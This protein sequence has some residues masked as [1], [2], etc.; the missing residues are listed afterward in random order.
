[1]TGFEDL[2]GQTFGRLTAVSRVEN[3]PHGA[4]RWSCSCACG[5]VFVVN[6]RAMKSGNTSSCGCLKVEI[7]GAKRRTHG[8]TSGL[9]RTREYSVW[10]SMHQRCG[11]PKT[12]MWSDYGGRGIKVCDRW[13]D[14][15]NFRDDM[16]DRPIGLTLERRDN[17]GGYSKENCVWADRATQSL[18][19]RRTR[20][21]TLCGERIQLTVACRRVGLNPVRVHDRARMT[22]MAPI[23]AFLI[24]MDANLANQGM[25]A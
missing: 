24:A 15:A 13:S 4:A 1:M 10:K 23:E 9:V 16:G 20:Y 21:I 11:N 17:N 14:F 5:A 2:T 3:T 8:A 22:G 12:K 25:S 18:N 7:T 6:A 19:T